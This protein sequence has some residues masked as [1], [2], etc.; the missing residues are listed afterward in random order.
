MG[1]EGELPF[2][3]VRRGGWQRKSIGLQLRLRLWGRV[4]LKIGGWILRQSLLPDRFDLPSPCG[5]ASPRRGW[6]HLLYLWHTYLDNVMSSILEVSQDA[7][8]VVSSFSP[9]LVSRSS[10]VS[11]VGVVSVALGADARLP[12][13]VVRL[14]GAGVVLCV[15]GRAGTGH[16]RQPKRDRRR[17][18][19]ARA[20]GFCWRGFV[21]QSWQ[22][23]VLR[24]GLLLG[25]W[26]VLGG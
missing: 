17:Q 9:C 14:S 12:R 21:K 7:F 25:L 15:P 22:T 6:R 19:S 8:A 13:R 4:Y 24:C 18:R 5:L 1:S 11:G 10:V 20:A 23:V 16:Y 3:G 2:G 26:Q